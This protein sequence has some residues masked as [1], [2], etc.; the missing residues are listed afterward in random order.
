MGA[1]KQY[2]DL[3]H[4][5]RDLLCAN[6]SDLINSRREEAFGML[7]L[8]GIPNRKV[9]R[10]RYTDMGSVLAP[11]Y[12]LNLRRL[13]FPLNPYDAFKCGVPNLSTCLFFVENDSLF[14]LDG[15]GMSQLPDGITLCS[16]KDSPRSFLPLLNSLYDGISGKDG[17]SL[18]ALNTMLAQDGL[19]IHVAPKSKTKKAI[20]I[21]NL[22][23]SDVDLM[24]NRRV[25]IVVEEEAEADILFC[26][27]ALD[28]RRFLTTQ[29]VEIYVGKGASL[30]LYC[31]EE[32]HSECSQISNVYINQEA[33]SH[34]YL[35][36]ITLQNG[37]SRTKTDVWLKGEKATCSLNGCVIASGRQHVDN[38]TLIYHQAPGCES[39]ET[40]K[41]VLDDK[42]VGAFAAK[43][44]VE[45]GAQKTVSKITNQNICSSKS[46]RML[47]QPM[48][49]IYA[50]DVK[51]SHGS[52]V[53]R[54]P[55]EALFYMRQRG[56]TASEAIMLL[57]AAFLNEVIGT[58][59]LQPLRDR[60][61][62]LVEKRLRGSLESCRGC[63]QCR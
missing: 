29:V 17:D 30:N 6:S 26:D 53:G 4:S 57:K 25:L 18:S 3:Y 19:L 34:V 22:L 35:N 2:T 61:Q 7:S 43:V 58:I 42:A 50:D 31:L 36:S 8:K 51:C 16:L 48:L 5:Q 12:G 52:T 44:L 41:Y 59:K 15:E 63:S 37:I 13:R 46:A 27:H 33:S 9:E 54:L 14:G 47:T 49:E 55:E 62:F 32:T 39:D 45:Q 20:Q 24:V 60:M 11:N 40:Y 28:L 56:I 23:R 21:V 1:E 38:N 10:Y